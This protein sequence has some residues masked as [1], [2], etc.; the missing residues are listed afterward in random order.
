[1]SLILDALRKSERTRQQTLTG[2][3]SATDAAHGHARVPVPWATLIGILLVANAL[4]LA[5]IFWRTH[6]GSEPSAASTVHTPIVAA[7]AP[8]YRP[9]IRSLAVE[10]AANAPAKPAAKITAPAAPATIP[11]RTSGIAAASIQA[12]SSSTASTPA[13]A[14]PQPGITTYKENV[15]VFDTLPLA[16]QQLL[17]PLHMEVHSYSEKPAESFVVINM[18]RYQTGETLKEG[19]KIISITPEGVVMEYDGQKFLLPRL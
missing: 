2:R 18:Q 8:E 4:V 15:P 1:M 17:P 10:A 19:P 12:T 14:K 13:M 9:Q 3:L 11:T 6:S 16:F 7:T 5:V